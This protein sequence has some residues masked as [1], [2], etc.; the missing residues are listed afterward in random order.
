MWHIWPLGAGLQDP[1]KEKRE[2]TNLAKANI[3]QATLLLA[4]VHDVGPKQPQMV[5]LQ[6]KK[7]NPVECEAGVWHLD[8]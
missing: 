5:H 2:D 4:T 1:K 6:E 8:T 7:V 3:D